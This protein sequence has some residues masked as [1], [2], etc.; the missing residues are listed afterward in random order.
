MR[1]NCSVRMSPVP[2]TCDLVNE[3]LAVVVESQQPDVAILPVLA[4]FLAIFLIKQYSLIRILVYLG[5]YSRKGLCIDIH[6][7]N[8][9]YIPKEEY[10]E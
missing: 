10:Y 9:Y 8:T 3:L 4:D 1:Q 6:I 7:P 5:I 2:L